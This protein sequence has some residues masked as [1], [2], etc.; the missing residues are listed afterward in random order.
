MVAAINH[1]VPKCALRPLS[2]SLHSQKIRRH[3]GS[4]SR[5]LCDEQWDIA[6]ADVLDRR[7][8]KPS[9]STCLEMVGVRL[10]LNRLNGTGFV[11]GL[12]L[13]RMSPWCWLRLLYKW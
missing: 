11:G 9:P 6:I 7:A 3:H 8:V 12:N 10:A 4:V 13:E 1:H 5:A 2:D